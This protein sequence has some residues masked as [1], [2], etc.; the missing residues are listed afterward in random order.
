MIFQYI[1]LYQYYQLHNLK[2]YMDDC[3]LNIRIVIVN[4]EI[5]YVTVFI[6]FLT[7]HSQI[8]KISFIPTQTW[9]TQVL[10]INFHCDIHL[11]IKFHLLLYFYDEIYILNSRFRYF[12]EFCADIL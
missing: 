7:S 6:Y 10:E 4:V 11:N 12:D 3:I 9:N 8:V 1:Q 5:I 2:Y